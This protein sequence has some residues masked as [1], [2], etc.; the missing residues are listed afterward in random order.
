MLVRYLPG[1]DAK[2][3]QPKCEFHRD[4][5]RYLPGRNQHRKTRRISESH[6][7]SRE[8]Y[9]AIL[10]LNTKYLPLVPI[11]GRFRSDKDAQIVH[12]ACTRGESNG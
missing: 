8:N 6:D 7:L 2:A 5:V 4:Q 3:P 1:P 10:I 9:R 12:P 11:P